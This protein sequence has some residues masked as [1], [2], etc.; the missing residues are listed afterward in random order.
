M[1]NWESLLSEIK[2]VEASPFLKTRID[3]KLSQSY[4][5]WSSPIFARITLVLSLCFLGFNL[6]LNSSVNKSINEPMQESY[7][8]NDINY[9]LYE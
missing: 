4:K 7:L 8:I 1:K 3:A 9:Q 5:D 6:W 2:T